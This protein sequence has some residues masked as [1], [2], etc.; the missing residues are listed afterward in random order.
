MLCP[1]SSSARVGPGLKMS[2]PGGRHRAGLCT[3]VKVGTRMTV[4][5]DSD[6]NGEDKPLT[7]EQEFRQEIARAGSSRSD[8]ALGSSAGLRSSRP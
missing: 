3:Q 5:D 7:P 8:G 6:A 1:S 4:H 2:S